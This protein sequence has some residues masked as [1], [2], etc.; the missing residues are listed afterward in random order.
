MLSLTDV[1]QQCFEFYLNFERAKPSGS[2]LPFSNSFPCLDEKE[3]F[4]NLL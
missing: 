4:C 1:F 3:T 2:S